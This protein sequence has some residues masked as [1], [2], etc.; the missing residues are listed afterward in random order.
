MKYQT[1]T[2]FGQSE[3]IGIYALAETVNDLAAQGDGMP[4]I[5]AR[6]LLPVSGEKSHMHAIKKRLERCCRERGICVD[7]IS[8]D[9]CA[10][11]SQYM[12]SVTGACLS[13]K[14][15]E[16]C[17]GMMR[18]GQD[19]VLAGRTG[20]SGTL[21]IAEERG[22]ELEKRFSSVFL[23]EIGHYRDDLFALEEIAAARADGASAV[24]QI[25]GGGIFAALWRLSKQ[26]GTG[27]DTDLKKM[28]ISQETVEICEYFRLN[29][30]QLTS[31]GS[32]LAVSDHGEILAEALRRMGAEASVIGSLTD[33]HDKII[34]NG[35]DRRF[36]DRPAP[37]EYNKLF[38]EDVKYE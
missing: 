21:R 31:T 36:I 38:M 25:G 3:N 5:S 13:P 27:L 10:G 35:E 32:F 28:S 2:A 11:V 1:R 24:C 19:I 20:A 22:A 26:A 9:R 37:D 29:P 33:N 6:I 15:Q 17:G 8:A 23:A 14:G 18:A 16:R 4:R 34:R 7:G 12:V 30:Y